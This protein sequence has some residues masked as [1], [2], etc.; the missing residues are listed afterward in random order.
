MSNTEMLKH[1]EAESPATIERVTGKN[2]LGPSE[3]DSPSFFEGQ[4]GLDTSVGQNQTLPQA[5]DS[6]VMSSGVPV[7]TDIDKVQKTQ[8]D[9]MPWK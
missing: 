1:I 5:D 6:I 2:L 9:L 4:R 8:Q 7:S 3:D